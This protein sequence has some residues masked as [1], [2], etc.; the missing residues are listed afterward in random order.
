MFVILFN[1]PP[2]SGKDTAAGFMCRHFTKNGIRAQE[3]KFAHM[4]KKGVHTSLALDVPVNAFEG[5]IKDEKS[6]LFF[7]LS[8]RDAYIE[9]SERYM[10]KVYGENVFAELLVRQFEAARRKGV[11]VA[12]VSDCGFEVEINHMLVKFSPIQCVLMRM[13][14]TGCDFSN[15]SRSY[16]SSLKMP[17]YD[18]KNNNALHY[19]NL[20]LEG[21]Y[22]QFMRM[23]NA[24]QIEF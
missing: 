23:R 12:C 16:L 1:G 8:P 7:G 11:T 10:K 2:S 19:L 17:S 5:K 6:P 24:K 3:F 22:T 15:D 21:Y 13:H 20:E 18:I 9:H 14:R 4:L